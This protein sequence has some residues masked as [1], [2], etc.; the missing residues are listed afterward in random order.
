M[1][2]SFDHRLVVLCNPKT[3]TTSL[4]SALKNHFEIKVSKSPKWKH[5]TY[6]RARDLFGDL[7]DRAGCNYVT[8]V[9]DPL[10][11]L[12]SWYRYRSRD[13]VAD[14]SRKSTRDISFEQFV[15]EWADGSTPRARVRTSVEFCYNDDVLAHSIYWHYEA[16]PQLTD[17]ISDRI[18]EKLELPRLNVS[19]RADDGFD[20]DAMMKLPRVAA[21]YELFEKIPAKR[22]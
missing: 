12:N 17:W 2:A 11:T 14:D 19:K 7:F 18:G 10:D 4:E 3:A 20:R 1:I 22:G 5:L 15:S 6:F 13:K 8:V 21:C 9:R 16:L